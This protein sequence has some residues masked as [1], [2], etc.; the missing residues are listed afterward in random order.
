MIVLRV[1]SLPPSAELWLPLLRAAWS[2][3]PKHT[4]VKIAIR[5]RR[6][7]RR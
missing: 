6:A 7:I 5:L 1:Q 2:E 3:S 4:G